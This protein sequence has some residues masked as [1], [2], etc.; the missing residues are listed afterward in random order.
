MQH[1]PPLGR[2]WGGAEDVSGIVVN[3]SSDKA[4]VSGSV[5][6]AVTI[7]TTSVIYVQCCGWLRFGGNTTSFMNNYNDFIQGS[8]Y[9]WSLI[10]DVGNA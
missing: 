5:T 9:S 1:Y 2:E 4:L 3:F 6:C 7:S 8:S 10:T